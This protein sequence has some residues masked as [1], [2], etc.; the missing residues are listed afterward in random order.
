MGSLGR[1]PGVDRP[2]FRKWLYRELRARRPWDRLVYA[3]LTAG[4]VNSAGGRPDPGGWDLSD[5]TTMS[6]PDDVNGAV[7]F[8]LRHGR[9]PQDLSGTTA[10]VFLGQQIQCAEC[11]D[12]PSA[13]WK[14]EDFRR[15]TAAFMRTVGRRLDR[16]RV[17]GIRRF[18]LIDV[19]R[20]G[21]GMR[22]RMRKTGYS[23]DDPRALDG[24]ALDG[25]NE[26]DGEPMHP[27]AAL[28]RWLVG[29]PNSWFSRA[30][31]NRMW[32]L[33][34]GEGFV[35]PVDDLRADAVP[36]A[37]GAFA[38]L[39]TDLVAHD[40]DVARLLRVICASQAYQRAGGSAPTTPASSAAPWS[41]F[42]L[43]PMGADQ[44]LDSVV[45]AAGLAPALEEVAGERLSRIKLRLRRSFRFTFDVDEDSDDDAFTGTVPQAL[46]LL[47]GPLVAASSTAMQ[48]TTLARALDASSDAGAIDEIYTA[49]LSRAPRPEELARWSDYLSEARGRTTVN[50]MRV[51]GPGKGLPLRRAYR[52]L[53]LP[54]RDAR[55]EALEDLMWVLL[56]SNEF[57]FVH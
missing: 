5:E 7:N 39:A 13:R 40:Y 37:A 9:Q 35:E 8:L 57:F 6:P 2:A 54:L 33:L 55:H 44:L 1:S 23:D 19:A 49:V 12:H 30:L 10:R 42:R 27:R 22:R 41:R 28:A 46:M 29:D 52:R 48:H 20:P 16:G 17:M 24:S 31:T 43:R 45:A 53:Q 34:L 36:R 18:E 21:R 26:E 25:V 32:G 14:Q 50:P 38:A 56:N 51:G 15:F 11:H 4:G 3:L 47:N